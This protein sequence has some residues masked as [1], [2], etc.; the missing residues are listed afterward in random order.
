MKGGWYFPFMFQRPARAG[1]ELP[2][3]SCLGVW[4]TKCVTCASVSI[5]TFSACSWG[6]MQTTAAACV[7]S[8]RETASVLV[9]TVSGGQGALIT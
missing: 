9:S 6:I 2:T 4:N 1:S 8:Q 5:E 7:D 3:S